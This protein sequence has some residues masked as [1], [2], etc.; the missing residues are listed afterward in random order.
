MTDTIVWF[1]AL[2]FYAPFHYLGPMLVGFLTGK[3]APEQRKRLIKAIAIDCTISMFVA[4][5]IAFWIFQ[6]NLQL[7]ML[8]LL[9][10]MVVPYLHIAIVRKFKTAPLTR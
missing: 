7:A 4:F 5:T 1:I 6:T 3:E 10:S 9:I 8:I 2:S